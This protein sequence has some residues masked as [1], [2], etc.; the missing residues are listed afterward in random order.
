[1]QDQ[2]DVA[3]TKSLEI[4]STNGT[5][6]LTF[7]L[8]RGVFV[9]GRNGTGKS[10]LVQRLYSMLPPPVKYIPGS[11]VTQFQDNNLSMHASAF[12]SAS[13]HVLEADRDASA[14]YRPR[15]STN[16]TEMAVFAIQTAQTQYFHNINEEIK[17]EGR[18]SAAIDKL[19]RNDAPL[20]RL[21]ALMA[22]ANIEVCFVMSE[23]EL[24][25]ERNGEVFSLA[26]MSDGERSALFI[27]SEVL[28]SQKGTTFVIDEPE[29]HLHPAIVIPLIRGLMAERPDCFFIVSTHLLDLASQEENAT[30]VLVRGCNW[31]NETVENWDL[32]ILLQP[33]EIP[34]S[35]R[36]D[37]Y[38][39][40]RKL[41]F[42][43]GAS[44]SLDQPL[45]SLLFPHVSI[46]TKETCTEVIRAVTGLRASEQLHHASAFGM[47]DGDG[48]SQTQAEEY[49]GQHIHTVPFYSV[50]SLYYSEPMI[51]AVAERQGESFAVPPEELIATVHE[52]ALG[53]LNDAT[54]ERLALRVSERALRDTMIAKMPDRD[55][56]AAGDQEITITL[57]SPYPDELSRIRKML[58]DGDLYALIA[59]YPVR[60][61]P[62]LNEVAK[63][64]RLTGRVD[65]EKLALTRLSADED[66]RETMSELLGPLKSALAA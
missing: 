44:T 17:R 30:I 8:N 62:V 50:E 29:L 10:A 43:E 15:N 54:V 35:L 14:R 26:M 16:R 28:V 38:G 47:I 19:L 27:V 24:R 1:M 39:A 22:Q 63:A 59:R 7:Q 46:R 58:A 42:I 9:L 34:E 55:E 33:E 5:E 56:L 66:L 53:A 61:S 13:R 18:E 48:M 37:L 12:R 51:R 32:N 64:L 23:G 21:N 4:P 3:H 25:A 20:D 41:L 40:R 57:H 2:F 45:Y 31:T 65:Y 49:R 60:E 6:T 11:R 36:N 52:R